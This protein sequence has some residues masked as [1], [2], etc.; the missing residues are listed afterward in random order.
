MAKR[1]SEQDIERLASAFGTYMEIVGWRY[2]EKV[3]KKLFRRR[4]GFCNNE[5]LAGQIETILSIMKSG[6]G[7]RHYPYLQK[8]EKIQYIIERLELKTSKDKESLSFNIGAYLEDIIRCSADFEC[9]IAEPREIIEGLRD[10]KG[11]RYVYNLED[12]LGNVE[13]YKQ[14]KK[15]IVDK[16]PVIRV[17]GSIL[18]QAIKEEASSIEFSDETEDSRRVLGVYYIIGAEK[19]KFMDMPLVMK[20]PVYYGLKILAGIRPLL[21]GDWQEKVEIT[22]EGRLYNLNINEENRKVSVNIEVSS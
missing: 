13:D 6:K 14:W 12:Y 1:L 2:R 5:N 9:D 16:P 17:L 18:T 11:D 10:I 3:T 19:H 15:W 4:V 7:R 20:H 8:L 21:E 22:W